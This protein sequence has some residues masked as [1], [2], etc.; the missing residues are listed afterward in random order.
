MIGDRLYIRT[1]QGRPGRHVPKLFRLGVGWW[2]FFI[3]GSPS[4]AFRN[5]VMRLRFVKLRRRLTITVGTRSSWKGVQDEK[6]GPTCLNRGKNPRLSRARLWYRSRIS[7]RPLLDPYVP[8]CVTTTR[9]RP[10]PELR[11]RCPRQQVMF[12]TPD[13]NPFSF[14]ASLW[15]TL[16]FNC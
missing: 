7:I 11:S 10:R 4:C 9:G 6:L 12:V 5:V 16:W 8:R 2:P 1:T 15:R 3:A 13:F 14:W